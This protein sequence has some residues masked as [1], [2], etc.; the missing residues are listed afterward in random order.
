MNAIIG[1]VYK[2]RTDGM[3][4][5][6]L[7]NLVVK[8]TSVVYNQIQFFVCLQ[9]KALSNCIQERNNNINM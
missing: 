7:S 3:L 8:R 1:K 4:W 6:T 9:S 2:G 5:M